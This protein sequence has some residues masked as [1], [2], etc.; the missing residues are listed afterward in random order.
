M[1]LDS[2]DI[3]GVNFDAKFGLKYYKDAT[4]TAKTT[5]KDVLLIAIMIINLKV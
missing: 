1:I 4:S 5:V 3:T 2:A